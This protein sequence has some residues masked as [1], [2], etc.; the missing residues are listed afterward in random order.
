MAVGG[1]LEGCAV[2]LGAD[3]GAQL[4]AVYR[5]MH[6]LE[7]LLEGLLVVVGLEL[8]PHDNRLR[9]RKKQWRTKFGEV[10]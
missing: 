6:F 8:Q 9:L 2:V 7:E 10:Y 3:H 5:L 4:L 1:Y